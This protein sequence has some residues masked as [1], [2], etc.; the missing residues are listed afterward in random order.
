M[1]NFSG[2]ITLV[3]AKDLSG[4]HPEVSGLT[5]LKLFVKKLCLFVFLISSL[6]FS[7]NLE[8]TI[9]VA[10]ETFIANPNTIALQVLNQQE[11]S[12]KKLAKTKDEQLALVF[13][14][15]HKG[16]YLD[17]N[18]QLKQAIETYEDALKRF[19]THELSK[20][21]DFDVIENCLIPLGNLYTKTGDYT[22]AESTIK[23]YTFL[24]EKNKNYKQE[25]TGAINLAQLYQTIGKHETVI[26]LTSDYI[27]HPDINPSQKQKLIALNVDGQ[28]ALGDI[29]TITNASNN[30]INYKIALKK[31]DYKTALLEFQNVKT[32]RL[33]DEKLQ[34]RDLAKLHVEEAQLYVLLNDKKK[35]T[36]NLDAAIKVLIPNVT[37]SSL[38]KKTDLYAENTFIDIFDV[39]AFIQQNPEIALESYNLSFYVS[40]LLK[41]SWTSQETK[42]LNE[43]NN[44]IRSEKCIDILYRAYQKTNE[45]SLLFKALQYSENNKASSLTEM[46]QKKLRLQKFP[47]DSLLIKEFNLL[48]EQERITNLLVKEQLNDNNPPTI[49]QLSK[50]LST[51]SLQLKA[52]K[53]AILSKY[54]EDSTNFSLEGLQEKLLQNEA[55]LVEYFYGKNTIYQFIVSNE[56]IS[57]HPVEIT[58]E[59][60]QQIT[61]FI[62]LFD[63][64]SIINNDINAFTTKAFQLYKFLKLD[65]ISAYKNAIIIPDGLLN[66]IPFETL[67]TSETNAMAFSKMPFVVQQQNIVYSSNISFYITEH[68]PIKND[69]LLGVFPV[70]EATEK[71]LTY[72]VK[73]ASA[74]K[75]ETDAQLLM[76]EKATKINFL[77]NATDYSILHLS[78][79]A[80][81]GDFITPANI[82]FYDDTLYLNAL[83][84]LDLNASLVVLSACETGIGKLYKGEGAMSIARGFQYAGVKNLLFSLWQINDLSTSQMMQS[85]YENLSS[86]TSASYSNQ[87]SKLDYLQNDAIN[88]AKKSPYYWGAFV[89][90]GKLTPPNTSKS[91]Y[92]TCIGIAFILILVF[93]LLK[94]KKRNGKDTA[95]IPS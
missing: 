19:N 65:R 89:Y 35:A 48:K 15:C 58:S 31:G 21:S 13:L 79:H 52:L 84:S 53:R 7:Q 42:I 59:T 64:A 78:T 86:S 51:I 81:S 4:F 47:K 56:N 74:I 20:L 30:E 16:H 91:I 2:Q 90:Y 80:S 17:Q 10:A 85:F 8:E 69:K 40:D 62:H 75:N 3:S 32:T 28:I 77:E 94:Y 92:Y 18:S 26:K 11:V 12:F 44:R 73:E 27:N 54:S 38:P 63:T 93:L 95:R 29:T 49:N 76:H 60:K 66:F 33:S 70:F 39:Y 82:D 24:A 41:D 43:T 72:S 46:F 50:N 87:K 61:D 36:Q 83:N 34:K 1:L 37:S 9:Y 22:N 57:M 68:Q 6:S 25:V 14:Q 88:N 23:H 45:K 71:Q 67:L 55:V 5:G